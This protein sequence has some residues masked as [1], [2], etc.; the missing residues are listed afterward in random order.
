MF[1]LS[2]LSQA[3]AQAL[4]GTATVVAGS[5]TISR[6]ADA[7]TVRQTTPKLITNWTDFNV[8]AG[9]TVT[10]IQPGESAVALNRVTGSTVSSI[11]GTLNGNGRVFLI[12]PSGVVVTSGANVSLGSL[13]ASTLSLADEDF[14]SGNYRFAG[15]STGSVINQGRIVAQ[16]AMGDSYIALIANEVSNEGSLLAGDRG[17]VALAAGNDVTVQLGGPFQLSVQGDAARAVINNSGTLSAPSGQ[18][19]LSAS[20]DS[21]LKAITI[22]QSGILKA[23]G[24]IQEPGGRIVLTASDGHVAVSG[25]VLSDS[26]RQGGWLSIQADTIAMSG[27]LSAVGGAGSQGIGGTIRLAADT[28]LEVAKAAPILA[29]GGTGGQ[30]TLQS[31]GSV[32]TEG[33]VSAAGATRGSG[34]SVAVSAGESLQVSKG[35]FVPS[36]GYGGTLTFTAPLITVGS[37]DGVNQIRSTQVAAWLNSGQGVVLRGT[38]DVEVNSDISATKAT[39]TSRGLSLLAG[40]SVLLKSAVDV[41][42]SGLTLVANAQ[43]PDLQAGRRAGLGALTMST[44][45]SLTTQGAAVL[46][47]EGDAKATGAGGMTLTR[48]EAGSLTVDSVVFSGTTSAVNKVYDGTRDVQLKTPVISGLTLVDSNLT[49]GSI[50]RFTDKSAGTGKAVIGNLTLAGFDVDDATRTTMLQK[51]GQAFELRTTADIERRSLEL[52]QF[53]VA[54]KVYDGTTR[55]TA[56]F[57]SDNRVQGDQVTASGTAAFDDKNVGARK[58]VTLRS[59]DLGGPDA[60]NYWPVATEDVTFASIT[61]RLLTLRGIFALDRVY[62]GTRRVELRYTGDDRVPGDQITVVATAQFDNAHAGRNKLVPVRQIG[63]KGTDGGNYQ[64]ASSQVDVYASITP[65]PLTVSQLSAQSKVYDGTRTAQVSVGADDRIAGDDLKFSAAAL[66]DTKDVGSGKRVAVQGI[67]LSGAN[68]GDYTLN[69]SGLVATADITPRLLSLSGLLA[70]DKIYDGTRLATVSWGVDDRVAG[71]DLTVATTASFDAKTAGTGKTVTVTD[72]TLGGA[73][74]GNYRV[75]ANGA[76]TQAAIHQRLLTLQQLAAMDKVY[77]QTVQAQVSAGGDD[78]VSGDQLTVALTGAFNSRDAGRDKTVTV[79]GIQLAGEDAL[80]YR[81]TDQPLTTQAS[82]TPRRLTVGTSAS[83][84]V[85]DGQRDASVTF[86]DDRLAGDQLQLA[87]GVSLFADAKAGKG[88][89]VTA[90]SWQLIGADAGNYQ[91]DPLDASNWETTASILPRVLQISGPAFIEFSK[92]LRPQTIGIR[93]DALPQ[94]SV[95]VVAGSL[96]WGAT[97]S[98]PRAATL[99]DLTLQGSGAENYVLGVPT[100]SLATVVHAPLPLPGIG[101]RW[102]CSGST[103]QGCNTKT[104]ALSSWATQPLMAEVA[105]A[106]IRSALVVR[107]GGILLPT[108]RLEGT[109]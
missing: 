94:D 92:S 31:A 77:D 82:I 73:D 79:T 38:S 29:T 103:Q 51:S 9:K 55:A 15:K 101:G 20:G 85:Y 24:L 7:V 46:K 12:N 89:T 78:R 66:F 102:A 76:T 69:A 90:S 25:S 62:D 99:S 19:L 5:A 17:T 60:D 1:A 32:L 21:R 53:H 23:S 72:V 35:D 18:V 54:D 52:S 70:A 84:K 44:G 107:E 61:P 8:S 36:T 28:K 74:A 45:S 2:L 83:D 37:T 27:T 88:K 67:T 91:L 3:M 86:T 43:A 98:L 87:G 65:R 10:F 57:G 93:H 100:L 109:D 39:N 59:L 64:V 63:L 71:D 48:V 50:G 13:V 16:T 96:T 108:R 41:G 42:K 106:P 47:V 81:V 33:R 56:Q 40:R 105:A 30:I 14:L 95:Q 26:E 58:R 104:S 80:N 34:G 75:E 11:A 6:T 22:N 68:A 49:L 97:G 4:P